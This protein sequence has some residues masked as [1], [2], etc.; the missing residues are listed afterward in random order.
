MKER[1]NTIVVLTS[2][3]ESAGVRSEDLVRLV[4]IEL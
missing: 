1:R 4:S 3:I 2:R